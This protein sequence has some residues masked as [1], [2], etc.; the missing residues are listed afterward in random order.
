MGKCANHPDR[1]TQFICMQHQIYL[2][3]ECLRCKDPNIYCKYRYSCTIWHMNKHQ[4]GLDEDKRVVTAVSRGVTFFPG[5][6]T[7]CISDSA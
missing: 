3:E 1:E 7:A 2:C 6:K 5:G 4:D